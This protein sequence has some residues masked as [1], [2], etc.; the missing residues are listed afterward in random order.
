M[1][2]S[3]TQ[4]TS[5]LLRHSRN[6]IRSSTYINLQFGS[7]W[8]ILS[9]FEWGI[10][11]TLQVLLWSFNIILFYVEKTSY[12]EEKMCLHY[13]AFF[14]FQYKKKSCVKWSS[15]NIKTFFIFEPTNFF[16]FKF[17]VHVYCDPLNLIKK[18]CFGNHRY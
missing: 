13:V 12:F 2:D 17:S 15:L 18:N 1:K 6:K 16:Q 3:S 7:S 14:V 8:E 11:S 9:L 10:F 5:T 4:V